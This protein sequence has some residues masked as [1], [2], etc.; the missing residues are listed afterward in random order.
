MIDKRTEELACAFA[1]GALPPEEEYEFELE[2]AT[3]DELRKLTDELAASTKS[4]VAVLP[5]HEPSIELK[6]YILNRIDAREADRK[7]VPLRPPPPLWFVWLP[8]AMAACFIGLCAALSSQIR[9]ADDENAALKRQ[10]ASLKTEAQKTHN[11]T[12]RVNEQAAVLA[13]EVDH[14]KSQNR[15]AE[16]RI[17]LLNSLLADATNTIAVSL[18]DQQQQNGVLVVH[19]LKLL[20]TDEDYQLWVIDA[21]TSVPVD[22]GV[23]QVDKDGNVRIEFKPKALI[24]LPDKF[25]V[26]EEP[27]GGRPTPSLD[28]M[29]LSGS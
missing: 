22:A 29:V 20:P 19:H 12:V 15:L 1:I 16:V 13:Q 14:L 23:F 11:Q 18:W 5:A 17:S 26:T 27:K 6:H 3:N 2:M 4:L 8:W 28:H 10:I 9:K 21:K 7:I 24:N 25:A